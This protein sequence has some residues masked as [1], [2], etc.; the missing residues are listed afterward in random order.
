M[1]LTSLSQKSNSEHKAT[2]LLHCQCQDSIIPEWAGDYCIHLTYNQVIFVGLYDCLNQTRQ[3]IS[4][5]FEFTVDHW[6][7]QSAIRVALPEWLKSR[8]RQF[9]F[10]VWHT[11]NP[12]SKLHWGRNLS[13]TRDVLFSILLHPFPQC[14]HCDWE[15][16]TGPIC[17][18]IDPDPRIK[19]LL[20]RN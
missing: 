7:L 11:G 8:V 6:C 3:C 12:I 16:A 15:A 9:W 1:P 5:P 20:W 17:I 14:R 4:E 10:S 2:G 19:N 18:R 13:S